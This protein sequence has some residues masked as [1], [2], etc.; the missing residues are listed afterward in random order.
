MLQTFPANLRGLVRHKQAEHSCFQEISRQKGR[1]SRTKM[2]LPRGTQREGL[3]VQI[4]TIDLLHKAAEHPRVPACQKYLKTVDE[5]TSF[6]DLGV[7]KDLGLLV[8]PRQ[9]H[10]Y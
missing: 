8:K 7:T 2:L 5:K 3:E 9:S 10:S 6:K 4:G 1:L